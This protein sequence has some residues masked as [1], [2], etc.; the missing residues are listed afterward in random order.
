MKN[1]WR[2]LGLGIALCAVSLFNFM[3]TIESKGHYFANGV[4]LGIGL[5]ILFR[6]AWPLIKPGGRA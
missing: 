1:K 6:T 4:L 2:P 5:S 3:L